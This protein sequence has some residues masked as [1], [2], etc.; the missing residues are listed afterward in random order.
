MNK[1]KLLEQKIA[2]CKMLPKFEK[3]HYFKEYVLTNFRLFLR[4]NF[5]NVNIDLTIHS[6]WYKHIYS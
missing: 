5:K 4:G 2:K 3:K 1:P 6:H